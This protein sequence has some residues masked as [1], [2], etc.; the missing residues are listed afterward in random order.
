L[1]EGSTHSGEYIARGDAIKDIDD[2]YWHEDDVGADITQVDAGM[3]EGE[4]VCTDDTVTDSNGTIWHTDDV[5][6]HIKQSA[7]D[8][9]VY[10][11]ITQL[12]I[13]EGETE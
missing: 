13:T 12:E 4:Y 2:N 10:V 5:D 8:P 11:D 1:C 6:V 3:H 7:L 9:T